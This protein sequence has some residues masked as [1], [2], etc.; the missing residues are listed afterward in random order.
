MG[1]AGGRNAGSEREGRDA[2]RRSRAS[3]SRAVV[4]AVCT[5]GALGGLI[6]GARAVPTA[7]LLDARGP[8]PDA[9]FGSELRGAGELTG[10]TTRRILHFTFDDGPDEEY[11][12]RLLD[13]LDA[14]G[15]KATFFF[16]TSRF[17]PTQ[18][19]HAYAPRLALEV[20]RRGHQVGSHGFDHVRMSRLRPPELDHQLTQSEAM[21]ASVFGTRTFLYRPPFGSR[22]AALDRRLAER[23]YATVMW[24]IG[25][26]DWV[27]REPDQV[28]RT[29][30]RA[31]ERNERDAGDRGG[32]VLMHDTHAWSVPA[33]ELIAE[34]IAARNCQL[35]AADEELYDVV[36]SMAPWVKPPAPDG[37]DGFHRER[38][39]SLRA[40]ARA[41][42]ARE[43]GAGSLGS[44]S[45]TSGGPSKK[46]E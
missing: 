10:A 44:G 37:S 23:G 35:L 11:T 12:P 40:R 5:L 16:S 29:F 14:A 39:A 41:R 45:T 3:R 33:F 25:M 30:W 18:R 36:D 1:A 43:E 27:E 32:I 26:A 42:C 4:A 38:Q 9:Q 8:I 31:L 19:R 2:L 21:F 46:S 22:N 7:V 6:A 20:A 28:R 13:A 24:N 17:D 34:S 15:F